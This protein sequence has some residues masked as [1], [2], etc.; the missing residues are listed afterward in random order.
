VSRPPAPEI[1]LI[2]QRGIDS[3]TR[4]NPNVGEVLVSDADELLAGTLATFF[5]LS[6]TG[7]GARHVTRS[8]P[9][10]TYHVVEFAFHHLGVF[11]TLDFVHDGET[12]I[13]CYA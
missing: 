10:T 5:F 12:W 1:L 9:R 3:L 4:P 6:D 8:A 11:G 13:N 2:S 7:L